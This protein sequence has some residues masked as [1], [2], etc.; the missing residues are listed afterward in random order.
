MP[1]GER[2][3]ETLLPAPAPLLPPHPLLR[4]LP[5]P[6]P[7]HPPLRPL[8]P[9]NAAAFKHEIV[10]SREGQKAGQGDG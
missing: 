5:R 8:P 10:A 6:M 3:E 9:P 2:A 1:D 4:P 7:P